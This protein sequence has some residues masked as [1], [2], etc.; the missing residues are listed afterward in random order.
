MIELH[1]HEQQRMVPSKN[2][3]SWNNIDFHQNLNMNGKNNLLQQVFL[4]QQQQQGRG[5]YGATIDAPTDPERANNCSFSSLGM[6]DLGPNSIE[7]MILN[8]RNQQSNN[9]LLQ[10][11]MLGSQN[12][13]SVFSGTSLASMMVR[14]DASSQHLS[15]QQQQIMMHRMSNQGWGGIDVS[16]SV[17]LEEISPFGMGRPVTS[18][19]RGDSQPNHVSSSLFASSRNSNNTANNN[20]NTSASTPNDTASTRS[21][22]DFLALIASGSM[23]GANN[24]EIA[25]ATNNPLLRRVGL[26]QPFNSVND[27]PSLQQQGID[28]KTGISTSNLVPSTCDSNDVFAENGMLGPWSTHAAGLLGNMFQ[29]SS[30]KDAEYDKKGNRKRPKDRPKRPLSAYNIFFKEERNR[31]LDSLPVN[32]AVNE[33]DGDV[34]D[35]DSST[36][37]SSE[38]TKP[39]KRKRKRR[40]PTP[41]GKIGFESL[42]KLIGKR[43]QELDDSQMNVYKQKAQNDMQ[44]YKTE[45]AEYKEKKMI[46]QQ[47]QQPQVVSS[48]PFDSSFLEPNPIL[49][50]GMFQQP[51]HNNCLDN[52]SS[53]ID[54]QQQLQ[55]LQ[56]QLQLQQQQK[57]ILS[58]NQDHWRMMT[59]PE[60]KQMDAMDK[61]GISLQQQ[62]WKRARL[63][64]SVFELENQNNG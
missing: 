60:G 20:Q 43:W 47:Q 39:K 41:H 35:K 51:I 9:L 3:G 36:H 49:E 4:Q 48:D 7:T 45:M 44:R 13:N 62:A 8:Q 32:A 40:G 26:V 19:F 59:V 54:L 61:I 31:I 16:G 46:Q 22:S 10:Q 53:N 64:S 58:N 63:E 33:T 14:N 6:S 21:S 55:Q 15:Q 38:G 56:Q 25:A 23:M 27:L 50:P 12:L 17:T 34:M 5:N 30:T 1:L 2:K 28:V 52:S 24:A 11:M 42:A 57:Q 37:A 18:S 29:D